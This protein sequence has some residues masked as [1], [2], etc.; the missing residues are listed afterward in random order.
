MLSNC[1]PANAAL[2]DYLLPGQDEVLEVSMT[3]GSTDG[4]YMFSP[5][6]LELTQ[7]RR[8]ECTK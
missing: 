8:S 6:T 4:K 3:L 2:K 7:V 5:S 1:A